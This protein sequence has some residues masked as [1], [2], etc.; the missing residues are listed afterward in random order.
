MPHDIR[1]IPASEFLRADVHGQIDLA[2]SK[3]L[4]TELA[5]A[6]RPGQ[7]IVIDNRSSGKANLTSLEI[8][9]LVQTLRALGL[10]LMNK[11]A[12]IR[13]PTEGFDRARFFQL[14]A[15]DR[16][17][18]VGAFADFEAALGWLYGEGTKPEA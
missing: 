7:H 1:V 15:N 4:L 9:D 13:R 2:S 16:G 6:V 17:F 12:I 14:L 3:A 18:E 8:Y 10:G 5:A 11:I